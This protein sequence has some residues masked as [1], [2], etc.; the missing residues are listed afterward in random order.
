M[1]NEFQVA[2]TLQRFIEDEVLPGTGIEAA[3]FW[4]G[5]STLVHDLAPQNRALL[6][7]RERLQTELD[8]WH[9]QHPGPIRDMAAYQHFLQGIGYLV[10]A[11]E[12]VQIST[13]NVDREIAVQAGPQLVVPLSNARYALNAANA[14]WGSLYDALY[15]T[16]AITETAGAERGQGYNPGRGAKVIAYGRQFLDA[17]APLDGASHRDAKAYAIN[18]G[19][20]HVTLADGR[21]V[22]LQSPAQLQGYQGEPSTPTA[23]LLQHHQLHFEIRIDPT[24]A[25]GQQDLAGVKDITLEA[26]LT[27]IIDCEDSV[28]AVD[29][30]DKVNVYRNWLGLMKGDL[31]EQVS[32]G[33]KAFSRTLAADRQYQGANG[34][35]LTLPGR[36]LLFIRN[37]GPLMTNPAILDRDGREIPEGI[38]DAVVTSLIGLH[39]LKRRG[40]SR[41][42]SLYIVKPKMH[43]PAE[44]AFADQL[45]GRVEA[46]LG[47]PAHTLKMGI[48]DEER[49]TSV[50]LKACI[51]SAASRVVFIN[52]GFLDRTGDEMHTAMEAGAMLR[53]GDMKGS[54]WIQAYE[55][56][57][58]MVGLACGLRG[59]AQIGKGMWAM[60][61]LMAAMLEQKVAQPKAGANTAWVPSPTAATLH[62]LHYHQVD[63]AAVQQALEQVDLGA[64]RQALLH[65]LLSIPVSPERVWSAADIQAEL[66]NN[67]QGI[68]GYVVRWVE[69]GVGCSK[70]PDIHDVGL[71]EDRATLRISAQHIANWLHHG[72]VDDKQ[73]EATLQR[74]AR[75]VDQQ[76]AGDAAYRPMA[77]GFEASH[78]FH[79]ARELVFKGREQPSGY[80]EPLLHGWRLRFKQEVQR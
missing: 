64:Q 54:A 42:G 4:Q 60:P 69:Q 37:V 35:P 61:D 19:T 38:L 52:T 57:N 63:V 79:A 18:Q 5:F 21:Q 50:N 17:S 46:L 6:A 2:P 45:F 1:P 15:G 43:G 16:D 59:K 80:T 62:A 14:R 26:A 67:C 55:R 48:M 36:S 31:S 65:D 74:M 41:E 77:A 49:R 70:V 11:P 56:S 29:A 33:G 34:Q 51:A 23:I 73:V 28:A 12:N 27:T 30:D 58:V 3:T 53:K 72:V 39:D 75:V 8:N 44:V 7:E 20:L 47:L 10:D 68:L 76:N 25:I 22:G 71:M 78:A 66:D 40:N 24:S 13:I 9:R 32:K